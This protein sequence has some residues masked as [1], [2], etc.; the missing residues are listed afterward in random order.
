MIVKENSIAFEKCDMNFV[1]KFGILEATDMVRNFISNHK[2]PFIFDTYQLADLLRM[3]R[4]KLF[5]ITK[6]TQK[7]YRSITL[8][9]KNGKLRVLNAP[10][11]VLKSIQ[12]IILHRIL[13][14]IPASDYATAYVKGK[15]ISDN[16]RAHVG[17]K[18]ILKMDITDFFG[19]IYF[20]DILKAVFNTSLFPLQIGAML[21]TLCTH[22]DVLPQG[23]PTSPALSNIVM[24]NF[25]NNIG[26][27]C[28]KNAVTYTRYCDDM[29]FSSD[30][31]LYNVYVKA[32]KMLEGMG[33]EVNEEKTRFVT[34]VS[35]QTVT[36]LT[37]NE[38]LSVTS[39]YKRKLRQEIHYACKFGLADALSRQNNPKIR[40]AEHYRNSLLGTIRFV[41]QIEPQNA[42]F[43][44]AFYRI[45]LA[46]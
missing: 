7:Y 17:K 24:R 20:E 14:K 44:D 38:K 5:N 26:A 22:N 18:Y 34:N 45:C 15:D 21:T 46:E 33:F 39:D 30:K 13:D 11:S 3:P 6:N 1:K 36:G 23:A 28:K 27:W 16:A 8:K 12:Q 9:K 4:K 40:D 25:D 31:P 32:R 19:S 42:W 2:T 29:T 41:L 10:N 35:R 37:V 43:R